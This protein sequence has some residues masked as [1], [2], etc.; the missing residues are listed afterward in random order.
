M[1]TLA[2]IFTFT[3][4][5]IFSCSE[6][7]ASVSGPRLWLN[8]IAFVKRNTG[9]TISL[10]EDFSVAHLQRLIKLMS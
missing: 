3:K 1:T 8:T 10:M 9:V 4:G 2:V 5:R 6:T 7:L